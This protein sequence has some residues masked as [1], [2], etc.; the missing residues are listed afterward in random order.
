MGQCVCFPASRS[1]HRSMGEEERRV[2]GRRQSRLI[3]REAVNGDT[4]NRMIRLHESAHRRETLVPSNNG[5]GF[6][7]P[8]SKPARQPQI[9][10]K[11]KNVLTLIPVAFSDGVNAGLQLAD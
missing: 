2:A 11:E 10:P 8:R 4:K 7:E 3:Y 5:A 6:S 9:L 1:Y